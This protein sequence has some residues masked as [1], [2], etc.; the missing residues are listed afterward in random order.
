MISLDA[1]AVSPRLASV[2][3][4]IVRGG[5]F[6]A[7]LVVL[8]LIGRTMGA[9]AV[10]TFAV[11]IA[12]Q[13]I[14]AALAAAGLSM[15]VLRA[16]G[17]ARDH[18]ELGSV[19]RGILLRRL[20]ARVVLAVVPGALLAW[21]AYASDSPFLP[22]G[23]PSTFAVAVALSA[24]STV[25]LSI[26][27]DALNGRGRPILASLLRLIV[28]RAIVTAV[29]APSAITGDPVDLSTLLL[30]QTAGT[31]TPA[32]ILLAW[33]VR[34]ALRAPTGAP[35][36]P[37]RAEGL[38]QIEILNML[39]ADMPT[40]VLP[41]LLAP[42][43]V[44]HVAVALRVAQ[45][46]GLVLSSLASVYAPRFSRAFADGNTASIAPL[47]AQSRAWVAFAFILL[48]GALLAP[49]WAFDLMGPGMHLA[50]WPLVLLVLGQVVDTGTGLVGHALVMVHQERTELGAQVAGLVTLLVALPIGAL[51]WG[52]TGFA[53][54]SAASVAVRKSV[55]WFGWTRW[56]RQ[57]SCRTRPAASEMAQ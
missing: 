52:A 2:G 34:T 19:V 50:R 15:G 10:G 33:G 56:Y 57:T 3:L 5:G 55:S 29:L 32:L 41:V 28:P 26:L 25:V 23:A 16:A 27:G 4:M 48:A 20:P 49:G 42:D 54:G 24:A 31:I 12:W 30:V 11:F 9:A 35:A 21:V 22:A 14:P 6:L 46:P 13:G 51:A 47:L 1:P 40:I 45:G 44:G 43:A 36:A 38:W 53:A 39:S 17:A 7:Q 8:G 37:L 18:S